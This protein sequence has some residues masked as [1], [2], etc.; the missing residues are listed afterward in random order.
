MSKVLPVVHVSSPGQHHRPAC[1]PWERLAKPTAVS[2]HVAATATGVLTLI[3][4]P[5]TAVRAVSRAL[6]G[7]RIRRDGVGRISGGQESNQWK[8]SG[9]AHVPPAA[10]GRTGSDCDGGMS[11]GKAVDGTRPMPE[12]ERDGVIGLAARQI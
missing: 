8:G 6:P 12:P 5:Y 9:A 4:P 2:R 7:G 10:T 11:G 3:L 1:H